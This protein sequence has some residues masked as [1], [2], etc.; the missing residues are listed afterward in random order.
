MKHAWNGIIASVQPRIRLT[1]SFDQRFE[2]YQGYTLVIDGFI[3]GEPGRFSVGIDEPAQIRHEFRVGDWAGGE[4]VPVADPT[5]ELADFDNTSKLKVTSRAVEAE[6]SPPPWAEVPPDLDE[7]QERGYRRL[8]ARVY[9]AKCLLCIWGCE[10]P[11]EMIIDHWNPSEKDYRTETFCFGPKSC[12]FY[13]AG[14]T[15][16]VPG[17]KG[18]VYEEEDWVDE[19][20]TAHRDED[21]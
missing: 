7:Y 11:V 15:R 4:S 20:A 2:T 5:M 1:R 3:D 21:D 14:P 9:E 13:K 12:R 18:M 19:D 17:R 6:D 10:M 8:S 16:K